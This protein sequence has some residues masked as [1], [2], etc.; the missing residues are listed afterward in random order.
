MRSPLSVESDDDFVGSR[1]CGKAFA[2]FVAD[3]GLGDTAFGSRPGLISLLIWMLIS[4]IAVLMGA[5]MD[6]ERKRCRTAAAG[7]SAVKS[8]LCSSEHIERRSTQKAFRSS[9]SFC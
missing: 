2:F 7:Q 1:T 5:E 3:F 8:R 9:R 6:A 4:D